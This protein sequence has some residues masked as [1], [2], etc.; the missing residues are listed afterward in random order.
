VGNHF[1]PHLGVGFS[2][3]SKTLPQIPELQNLGR[4][5]AQLFEEWDGD[6]VWVV[7]SDL[8]HTHLASGPYGYR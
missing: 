7:S 3:A 8:A 4:S 1:L 5:F 6:V 2:H